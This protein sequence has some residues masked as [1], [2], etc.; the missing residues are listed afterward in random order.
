MLV[1]VH[2]GLSSHVNRYQEERDRCEVP[3]NEA[4]R[5]SGSARPICV[6][7]WPHNAAVQRRRAAA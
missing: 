3:S 7:G 6:S 2:K 1:M 5:P 4:Q